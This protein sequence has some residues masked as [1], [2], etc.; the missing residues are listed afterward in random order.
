[1]KRYIPLFTTIA[2]IALLV[3]WQPTGFCRVST[4]DKVAPKGVFSTDCALKP[5]KGCWLSGWEVSDYNGTSAQKKPVY[6][7]IAG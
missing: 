7:H 3:L 5:E 2:F 6:L 4:A 1:M